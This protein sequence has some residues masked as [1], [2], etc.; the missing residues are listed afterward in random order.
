M[1]FLFNKTIKQLDQF[2]KKTTKKKK[3]KKKKKENSNKSLF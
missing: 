3:K 1:L 2:A